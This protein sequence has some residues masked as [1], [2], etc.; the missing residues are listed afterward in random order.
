MIAKRLF[1][2]AVACPAICL[3]LPAFA[4]IALWIKIDSRGPVFFVQPRVGRFGRIFRIWK[5]RTMLT[6]AEQKK[7][8]SVTVGVDPRITRAGLIL[9]RWKVDELPQLFNVI[10]GDMSLV[11]PRPELETH[12]AHLD[13]SKTSEMLAA[14]PGITSPSAIRFHNESALLAQQSDPEQYYVERL[15]PRKIA[16]NRYYVKQQSFCYDLSIILKTLVIL[17]KRR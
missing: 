17:S 3:L 2:I 8:L 15:L 16:L 12:I 14:R 7:H 1:D 11:G 4:L 13:T 5:F 6:E 9:R 10:N